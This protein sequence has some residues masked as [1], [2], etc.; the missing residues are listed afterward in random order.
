MS[1]DAREQPIEKSTRRLFLAGLWTFGTTL[2][3]FVIGAFRFLIP[4]VDYGRPAKFRAGEPDDYP[5]G[6]ATF[7]PDEK[8]YI[9]REGD[10]FLAISAVCTHLGCTVRSD[11]EGGGYTCPCHGSKFRQDG[12]NYAGPAPEP[13]PSFEVTKNDLGT[14][15]IDKNGE[16]DRKEGFIV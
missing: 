13:L 9:V 3:L 10:K 7:L 14:L 6:I 1:P 15:I 2:F 16:T 11:G 4:N 8:V 5:D 12:T